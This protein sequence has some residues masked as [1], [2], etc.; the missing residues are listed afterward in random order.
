MCVRTEYKS[1][2]LSL[3][4]TQVKK[5]LLVV[6]LLLLVSEGNM[7]REMDRRIGARQQ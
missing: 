5:T 4:S 3:T 7:E 1:C 6:L 2:S